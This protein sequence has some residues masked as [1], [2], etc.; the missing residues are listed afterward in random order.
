MSLEQDA[1]EF[2]QTIMAAVR[3]AGHNQEV[4]EMIHQAL[5]LGF[6]AGVNDEIRKSNSGWKRWKRK[7]ERD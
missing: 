3:R 5:K 4:E 7:V 1:E 2:A 6:S